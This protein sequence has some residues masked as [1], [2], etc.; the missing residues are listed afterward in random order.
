MTRARGVLVSIVTY[1]DG[2]WLDAC[3]ESVFAQTVPVEVKVFD[4]G[5]AD[6]SR[7][8]ARRFPVVLTE[9]SENLGFSRAHNLNLRAGDTEY[10]LVLNPDTRL[11]PL[12]LERLLGVFAALPEAGMAGG[13]LRRM[14]DSGRVTQEAGHPLLDSTGVFF[15]PEQRH[16]DRGSG[17]Q[18]RGQYERR[19][20][21]FGITGAVLLCRRE[22]LEDIRAGD[23]FFDED[24]FAY[25]EDADLAWRARL[26]GWKA[27]YEPSAVALHRRSVLPSNRSKTSALINC[28][29]LKNRFLMRLKNMDRA[30][31]RRCFPHM[32]LR[33]LSILAY[34]LALERSSMRAYSEVRRLRP[35]FQAKRALIQDRRKALPEEMAGWFDFQPVCRDI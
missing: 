22:M 14:N 34:V 13:K 5:S 11:D 29:S 35:K 2:R 26:R 7:T 33:D 12:Y 21:V 3:L 20:E 1:N 19:Q 25:R 18:D 24:F 16:F 23:E 10:V 4:N 28:H 27:V 30:V 9:S 8:V 17:R 31:R 15:T 6:S 32:L